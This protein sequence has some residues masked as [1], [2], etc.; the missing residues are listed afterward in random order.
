M[1]KK[2][3][4]CLVWLIITV[5]FKVENFKAYEPVGVSNTIIEKWRPVPFVFWFETNSFLATHVE[6]EKLHDINFDCK[7]L[8][9]V[10][11]M[12]NADTYFHCHVVYTT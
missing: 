11:A 8:M 1:K 3:Q 12:I 6:W 7:W 2:N 4:R 9:M 5:S 10:F